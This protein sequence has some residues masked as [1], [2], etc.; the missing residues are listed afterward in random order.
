M[1]SIIALLIALSSLGLI[2]E[3]KADRIRQRIE[4]GNGH[5]ENGGGK[6]E[7]GPGNGEG[8]GL[9]Q[10]HKIICPVCFKDIIGNDKGDKNKKL[11]HRGGQFETIKAVHP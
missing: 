2:N 3:D 8:L 4:I 10:F 6:I 9:G 1:E 7:L 5:D 11:V